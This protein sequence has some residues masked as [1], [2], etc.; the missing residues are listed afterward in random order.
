MMCIYMYVH[1]DKLYFIVQYLTLKYDHTFHKF[2]VWFVCTYLESLFAVGVIVVY[3][4]K[5]AVYFPL[6]GIIVKSVNQYC[7]NK[8]IVTNTM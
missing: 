5:Y 6:A 7:V 8:Q 1:T 3:I 4:Q 2:L